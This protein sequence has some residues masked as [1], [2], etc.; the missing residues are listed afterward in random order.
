MRYQHANYPHEPG[1]LPGCPACDWTCFCGPGVA[2]GRET[3]CVW[4]GHENNDRSDLDNV[5]VA[6][7]EELAEKAAE[8]AYDAN[9][10]WKRLEDV[11]ARRKRDG[12]G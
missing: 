6:K 10:A 8:D 7:L 3:E 4:L 9:E 5:P 2:E 11:I 12:V 1:R